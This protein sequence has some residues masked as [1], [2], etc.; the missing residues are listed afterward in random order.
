M[1]LF[2]LKREKNEAVKAKQR[3]LD[4]VCNEARAFSDF[5]KDE[6]VSLNNKI[7]NLTSNIGA[8]ETNE[9]TTDKV[10]LKD[11]IRVASEDEAI[12]NELR[13]YISSG[14]RGRE[15]RAVAT[16]TNGTTTGNVGAVVI[17]TYLSNFVVQKLEEHSMAFAEATKLP[18]VTGK[19]QL[20]IDKEGADKAV[21]VEEGSDL[22]DF[23]MLSF[24]SVLFDQLRFVAGYKI[25]QQLLNNSAYSLVPYCLEKMSIKHA[26]MIEKQI[27]QGSGT[28]QFEGLESSGKECSLQEISIKDKNGIQLMDKFVEAV[29]TVHPA[30]LSGAKWYMS[31][32]VYAR[33]AKIKSANGDY[34]VQMG[35]QNGKLTMTLLGHPIVVTDEVSTNY[36]CFFG[37]MKDT[38]GIMVKKNFELKQIS[39]DTK[40]A[41]AGTV[42]LL[43]DGYFD[44]KV[45]NKQSM[46]KLK[47]A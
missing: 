20:T 41:I 2:D 45:I 18:S 10:I 38:Y 13:S 12:D 4:S 23:K 5:E 47:N 30:Y 11:D 46:V 7:A 19:Y 31:R 37:S 8:L 22:A 16:G 27:F 34:F 25:T 36:P 33:V 40:N 24:G 42:T 29:N 35:E 43:L 9:V 26:R 44:G 32:A 21:I 28:K 14:I 17:P 15:L 39:G 1:K 3:I 6:L